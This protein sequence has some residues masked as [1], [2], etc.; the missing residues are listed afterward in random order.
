[1]KRIAFGAVPIAA[2]AAMLLLVTNDATQMK[3]IANETAA[4]N[5][6]A[7]TADIGEGSQLNATTIADISSAI[8]ANVADQEVNVATNT[9]SESKAPANVK[10]TAYA[11]SIAARALNVAH[12]A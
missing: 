8:E 5:L 6:A 9:A 12:I 10:E 4:T 7:A 2:I 1:M 3:T 11:N